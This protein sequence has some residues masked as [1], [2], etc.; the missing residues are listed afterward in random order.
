MDTWSSSIS[1][2]KPSTDG[3]KDSEMLNRFNGGTKA[4]EDQDRRMYLRFEFFRKKLERIS[5]TV[6]IKV[7]IQSKKKLKFETLDKKFESGD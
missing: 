4:R 2:N 1:W 7:W 6:L 5:Q 3:D